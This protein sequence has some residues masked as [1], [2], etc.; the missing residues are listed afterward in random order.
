MKLE[1]VIA[2]MLAVANTACTTTNINA[3]QPNLQSINLGHPSCVLDCNTTQTATQSIGDGDVTGATVTNS[4][5]RTTP[6][7]PQGAQ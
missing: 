7:P 3:P 1:H 6:Q 4:R 5:T 2:A